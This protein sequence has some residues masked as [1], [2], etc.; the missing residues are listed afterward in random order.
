MVQYTLRLDDV[1]MVLLSS[2]ALSR[3]LLGSG[4][5]LCLLYAF[6]GMTTIGFN[7]K[8]VEEAAS[9][10]PSF[11][12]DCWIGAVRY[13]R[14]ISAYHEPIWKDRSG[15]FWCMRALWGSLGCSVCCVLLLLSQW[16][17]KT[18][19]HWAE[20][21]GCSDRTERKT[22]FPGDHTPKFIWGGDIAGVSDLAAALLWDRQSHCDCDGYQVSKEV[23]KEN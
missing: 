15:N 20:R 18:R 21:W 9:L 8:F 23:R 12:W 14:T 2:T 19:W 4:A 22:V 13:S 10:T 17:T 7:S 6:K 5:E 1:R 16:L 3:F 11:L